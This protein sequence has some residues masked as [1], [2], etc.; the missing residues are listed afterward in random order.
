ME[1]SNFATLGEFV[2]FSIYSKQ[3]VL[4]DSKSA[5]FTVSLV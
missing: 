2:F 1:T 5:V 3:Y 4:A